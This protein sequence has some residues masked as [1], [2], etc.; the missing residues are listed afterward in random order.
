MNISDEYKEVLENSIPP[1]F[2]G[3]D[4]KLYWI[5][6][7]GVHCRIWTDSERIAAGYPALPKNFICGCRSHSPGP[8]LE[9][10]SDDE[11]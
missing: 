1:A 6:M 5:N 2:I 4:G 9:E 7:S 11:L 10:C 8:H 3:E